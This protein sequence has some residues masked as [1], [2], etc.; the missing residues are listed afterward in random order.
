MSSSDEILTQVDFS[1]EKEF[2]FVAFDAAGND[3]EVRIVNIDMNN[4]DHDV[5]TICSTDQN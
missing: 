2:R 3:E 5:I 4:A 1:Y